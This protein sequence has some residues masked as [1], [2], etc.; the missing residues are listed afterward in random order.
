MF[1]NFYKPGRMYKE[2]W[3]IL[4]WSW[5]NYAPSYYSWNSPNCMA[6]FPTSKQS[7]ETLNSH[8]PFIMGRILHKRG[9]IID[10]WF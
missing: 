7:L 9:E 10:E 3:N 6:T 4:E 1:E 2:W 5:G 8:I